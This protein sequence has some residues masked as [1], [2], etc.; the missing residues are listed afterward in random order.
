MNIDQPSPNFRSHRSRI[1]HLQNLRTRSL[2]QQPLGT[3]PPSSPFANTNGIG[4]ATSPTLS[5]PPP[6]SGAE[7]Q[8][9]AVDGCIVHKDGQYSASRAAHHHRPNVR[10]LQLTIGQLELSE[11]HATAALRNQRSTFEALTASCV[12][13]MRNRRDRQVVDQLYQLWQQ[14]TDRRIRSHALLRR[15]QARLDKNRLQA[16]LQ[17]WL[18]ETFRTQSAFIRKS[19]Q[20]LQELNE[21]RIRM[22]AARFAKREAERAFADATA[23]LRAVKHEHADTQKE[24]DAKFAQLEKCKASLGTDDLHQICAELIGLRKQNAVLRKEVT[25]VKATTADSAQQEQK[26]S[27]SLATALSLRE[28]M[29]S[30]ITQ[31]R[32]AN[33]AL[34]QEKKDLQQEVRKLRIEVDGAVAATRRAVQAYGRTLLSTP[35]RSSSPSPTAAKSSAPEPIASTANRVGGA[36]YAV[37]T[38]KKLPGQKPEP[39]DDE[40]P[41]DIKDSQNV[42]KVARQRLVKKEVL[43]LVPHFE[44][45]Q[46]HLNPVATVDCS[47][48]KVGAA[49]IRLDSVQRKAQIDRMFQ[50]AA[51]TAT[52]VDVSSAAAAAVA[53]TEVSATIFCSTD[54]TRASAGLRATSSEHVEAQL[55]IAGPNA[56]DQIQDYKPDT[57]AHVHVHSDEAGFINVPQQAA[58]DMK[59]SVRS[60]FVKQVAQ[61]SLQKTCPSGDV[62]RSSRRISSRPS[63][64][65]IQADVRDHDGLLLPG[66]EVETVRKP[67]DR[68]RSKLRVMA[69]L[70]AFSKTRKLKA[71]SITNDGDNSPVVNELFRTEDK[72]S[73]LPADSQN[74]TP[75]P[76]VS[77]TESGKRSV[78][79][80]R[81]MRSVTE[82]V[83]QALSSSIDM[84]QTADRVK[85]LS[86][87]ATTASA[88]GSTAVV[89]CSARMESMAMSRATSLAKLSKKNSKDHQTIESML[90][91]AAM[92]ASKFDKAMS[93][94]MGNIESMTM[95]RAHAV[96]KLSSTLESGPCLAMRNNH[97]NARI[98]RDEKDDISTSPVW[99]R[100][101]GKEGLQR[102]SRYE[103]EETQAASNLDARETEQTMPSAA[104]AASAPMSAKEKLKARKAEKAARAKAPKG[105]E[106]EEE[107]ETQAA[108]NS[109]ARETEQTMPSAATAA[110][111]PMSAKEKLKARKAEKAARAKA[112]KGEEEE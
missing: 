26:L 71:G 111:A 17:K 97:L 44:A 55:L 59:K 49:E 64:T 30:A 86:I 50:A 8:V 39:P 66:M 35:T 33:E 36:G 3:T 48:P 92:N 31:L 101:H 77:E 100:T 22:K 76:A 56:A 58:S 2:Q 104:T 18:Q 90:I 40:Q 52:T 84:I 32:Q 10:Q 54:A 28:E 24:L 112:P 107:E 1:S 11:A 6:L 103:E 65:A 88:K 82:L 94:R 72:H 95:S 93:N 110:S 37:D 41:K 51:A 5:I 73:A 43:E 42:N 85:D 67:A 75:Q 81:E 106:E 21:N 45:A 19:R 69:A 7:S 68:M 47:S 9:A 34:Q 23:E 20:D 14:Q 25:L 53:P 27:Q 60:R 79:V 78:V 4:L 91:Q 12:Q 57:T 89:T 16:A 62:R 109:D 61:K 74:G 46:L 15:A 38:V 98:S 83:K 80:A 102:N 105:E 13:A 96:S 63:T 108:S 87:A 99:T 70:G 29:E